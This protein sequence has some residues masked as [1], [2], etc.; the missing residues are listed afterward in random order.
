VATKEDSLTRPT[1]KLVLAMIES[2][3]ADLDDIKKLFPVVREHS[4]RDEASP[5]RSMECTRP[6][7]ILKI[8]EPDPEPLDKKALRYFVETLQRWV[9]VRRM[10]AER[11]PALEAQMRGHKLE[12]TAP[13]GSRV[14]SE[15]SCIVCEEVVSRIRR[16]MCHDDYTKW[17][18]DGRQDVG[19]W[20]PR[21][22]LEIAAK[23]DL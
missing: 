16:G 5:A 4:Q 22:R 18:K 8:N 10:L 1:D 15:G 17:L 21:R 14:V 23:A 20:I 9:L 6:D 11:I 12:D 2:V 7:A 3:Q 19:L 13:V